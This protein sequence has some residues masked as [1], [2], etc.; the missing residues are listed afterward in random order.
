MFPNILKY[1]SGHAFTQTHANNCRVIYYNRQSQLHANTWQNI[2]VWRQ[3]QKLYLWRKCVV[4]CLTHSKF[5]L[6][7]KIGLIIGYGHLN[8]GSLAQNVI[9]CSKILV[10]HLNK[11]CDAFYN[12]IHFRMTQ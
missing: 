10:V 1:L 2:N 3:N 5:S 7:L 4:Q 11:I 8:E 6:N 9:T 12:K